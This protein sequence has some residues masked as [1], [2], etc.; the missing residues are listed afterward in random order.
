M[1]LSHLC[2]SL[3][4]VDGKVLFEGLQLIKGP[5]PSDPS[6][7]KKEL[8]FNFQTDDPTNPNE[9]LAL[10][11]P[12]PLYTTRL[13]GFPLH[14]S[15]SSIGKVQSAIQRRTAARTTG[16]VGQYVRQDVADDLKTVVDK[17]KQYLN[18]VQANVYKLSNQA[19]IDMV[20]NAPIFGRLLSSINSL[21]QAQT[22]GKPPVPP[23]KS[24]INFSSLDDDQKTQ[25]VDFRDAWLSCRRAA[26][27]PPVQREQDCSEALEDRD[28]LNKLFTTYEIIS[29]A[30]A[31]GT[32]AVESARTTGAGAT[33]QAETAREAFNQLGNY[34]KDNVQ[35]PDVKNF[36]DLAVK[37]VQPA[38]QN[39]G[40]IIP[41]PSRSGINSFV[42]GMCDRFSNVT[43][44]P[45]VRLLKRVPMEFDFNKFKQAISQKLERVRDRNSVTARAYET[46]IRANSFEDVQNMSAKLISSSPQFFPSFDQPVP[47]NKT[48]M[49]AIEGLRTMKRG[50]SG[51]AEE[52]RHCFS[53]GYAANIDT[54]Q[55]MPIID[56][57][58]DNKNIL[59]VDDNVYSGFTLSIS[60]NEVLKSMQ[61][62]EN[63]IDKNR[64]IGYA[65]VS[66]GVMG[67]GS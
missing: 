17:V 47:P 23:K 51:I 35:S 53:R 5:D 32:G 54:Q 19:I 27:A 60:L 3:R 59:V 16:R 25:L 52:F 55:E 11:Q 46:V 24:D 37:I 56:A 21:P 20:I 18:D 28:A 2:Q 64:I 41:V 4:F 39:I 45:I 33:A 40:L 61:S 29:N 62:Y 43:K 58:G 42:Q 26:N 12:D 65:V 30:A 22:K 15:F 49:A 9:V 31:A 50:I 44:A 10:A 38:L 63:T 67:S 8:S 34:V 36:M 13:D 48:L 14:I 6:K 66:P 1:K 7:T 57:L